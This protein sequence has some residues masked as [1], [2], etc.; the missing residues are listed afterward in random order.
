MTTKGHSFFWHPST[1]R[2]MKK[3]HGFLK[4][5]DHSRPRP[6][7]SFTSHHPQAD[8]EKFFMEHWRWRFCYDY[9]IG[10]E[11]MVRMTPSMHEWSQS[12]HVFKQ[13]GSL[14]GQTNSAS[15]A[16]GLALTLEPHQLA[17]KQL[18]WGAQRWS[19]CWRLVTWRFYFAWQVRQVFVDWTPQLMPFADWRN[20][21]WLWLPT[22]EQYK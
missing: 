9:E 19:M 3:I 1:F 20:L 21:A 17:Q 12:E 15:H 2:R 11:D 14:E 16:V 8:L 13:K 7:T 18:Q 4:F 5:A 22:E 10:S 6:G